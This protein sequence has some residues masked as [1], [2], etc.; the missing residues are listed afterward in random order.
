VDLRHR[1]A[2]RAA[3]GAL[4]AL[5]LAT[6]CAAAKQQNAAEA[7]PQT[8]PQA[9]QPI[10]SNAPPADNSVQ[11][12]RWGPLSAAD[13]DLIKKVRLASLWEMTM[14]QEATRKA[15]SP[16]VRRISGEIVAQHMVLDRRVR[17]VAAKL[18]VELPTEPSDTQ[19]QWMADIRAQRGAQYDRTYVK[20]LRF[21][22]GQVFALVGSVR[23][24]TR[25]RLV[26]PFA[27]LCNRFVLNHQRLLERT[28]LTTADS[29][30]PPPPVT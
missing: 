14:A 15:K 5:L 16:R 10:P 6:G 27:D 1:R 21:A 2:G 19:Q 26:R 30:P 29:F 13:R 8:V 23:G 3:T 18:K 22:H 24:T 20:W 9:A 28:G 25:N 4:T 7:D 17:N 12:T 11:R